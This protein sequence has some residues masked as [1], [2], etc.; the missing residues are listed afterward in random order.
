MCLTLIDLRQNNNKIIQR[1]NNQFKL[2]KLNQRNFLTFPRNWFKINPSKSRWLVN[3]KGRLIFS[4]KINRILMI[5]MKISINFSLS[6]LL[7]LFVLI[8]FLQLLF[9]L[10]KSKCQ[11]NGGISIKSL[12]KIDKI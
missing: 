1:G 8:L 11:F 4:K 12:S 9:L 3:L 5:K 6:I 7:I 10:V 2:S